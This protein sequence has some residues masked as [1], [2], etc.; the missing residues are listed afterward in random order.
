MLRIVSLSIFVL[1]FVL[2]SMPYAQADGVGRGYSQAD[3]RNL[4]LSY[5]ALYNSGNPTDEMIDEYSEF[6]YCELYRKNF[7][8][9]FKWDSIRR[10]IK[11]DIRAYN[12][13]IH[14]HYEIDGELFLDRYDFDR[15]EFPIAEK[16][17]LRNVGQL[18]IFAANTYF[19]F[20][21]RSGT[22][23]VL[24][25][26]YYLRLLKPLVLLKVS[27]DTEK[28][29]E[30]I[31][32]TE[33]SRSGHRKVYS[34]FRFEVSDIF[35]VPGAKKSIGDINKASFRGEIKSIELFVDKEMTKKFHTIDLD[36]QF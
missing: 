2:S 5:L 19:I 10:S 30:V 26:R 16:S 9:D 20:C 31:K 18:E 17:A 15:K 21:N 24:P 3:Y 33:I 7:S 11:K 34:R 6:A 27:I 36:S 23:H 28:A 35:S 22:L 1:A 13:N 8:D 4:T 14:R 32:Y 29:R 25:E 12:T